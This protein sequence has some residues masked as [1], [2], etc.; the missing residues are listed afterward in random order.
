[1]LTVVD[2]ICRES[3]LVSRSAKAFK[4]RCPASSLFLPSM[5]TDTIVFI[6]V[7][8]FSK[9]LLDETASNAIKKITANAK[10]AAKI[11][12]V[13][14]LKGFF[15]SSLRAAYFYAQSPPP[16]FYLISYLIF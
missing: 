10:R 9:L 4:T 2:A 5:L 7:V 15:I 12:V 8:L 14:L 6:K 11:T 3:D 1:M 16:R 13:F